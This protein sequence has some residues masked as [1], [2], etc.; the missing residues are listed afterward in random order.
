MS[1][2]TTVL[3]TV[4]AAALLLIVIVIA[5]NAPNRDTAKQEITN[6]AQQT[7]DATQIQDTDQRVA[8]TI[9]YTD[10]GFEPSTLT[11]KTGDTVRIQNN[12]TM[13]LSFNSDDHPA[14]T[15]YSELNVG[16]VPQGGSETFT[17]TTKG[18]WGFHNH[19]NA[20]DTGTITVE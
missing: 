11:V 4:V 17:V 9:S 2:K 3:T 18:T 13:S 5:L 1:K 19:D 15:K 12:S 10:K 7:A 20:S 6:T 16:D 14:H 8:A